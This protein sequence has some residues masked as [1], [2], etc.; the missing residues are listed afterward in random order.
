LTGYFAYDILT[1]IKI[2]DISYHDKTIAKEARIDFNLLKLLLLKLDVEGLEF[3]KVDMK[4]LRYLIND[5]FSTNT[6]TDNSSKQLPIN[7]DI[8]NISL[9]V[10]P[11]KKDEL[12]IASLKIFLD[13]LQ[14][15]NNLNINSLKVAMQSNY[16]NLNYKGSY[17]DK[18]LHINKLNISKLEIKKLL[19]LKDLMKKDSSSKDTLVKSLVV[20]RAKLSIQPYS[21]KHYKI[22][23]LDADVFD[24]KLKDSNITARALNLK[25]DTNIWKLTSTG[26]VKDSTFFS[27]VKVNL[28]NKYFQKF[29]PNLNF[30]SFE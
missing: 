5:R 1:K 12:E 29:I 4:N 10:L 8:H 18:N 24:F 17:K 2:K 6:K 3:K 7:I 13:R 20:D 26:Y 9:D 21:K 16:F 27:K 23:S 22:S 15:S 25:V 19:F 28:N 11:Y 14:L 30:N